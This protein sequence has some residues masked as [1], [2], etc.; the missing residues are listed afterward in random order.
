[1]ILFSSGL[2]NEK[3][4]KWCLI[5]NI[6]RFSKLSH[7]V[8]MLDCFL[9]FSYFKNSGF[10]LIQ[11]LL[12]HTSNTVIYMQNGCFSILSSCKKSGI[13]RIMKCL[14]GEFPKFDELCEIESSGAF[15]TIEISPP[16]LGIF[17]V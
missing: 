11:K 6:L 3:T 8:L 12:F 16:F 7:K 15:L 14:C 9:Y 2:E 10:A 17:I 13:I 5:N 4:I 1:M